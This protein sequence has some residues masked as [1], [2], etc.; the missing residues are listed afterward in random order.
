MLG[1]IRIK[2]FENAIIVN[3]L[4]YLEFDVFDN[5]FRLWIGDERNGF[6]SILDYLVVFLTKNE[7][8][9][10][11]NSKHFLLHE[12]V[13]SSGTHTLLAVRQRTRSARLEFCIYL[14]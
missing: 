12:I 13:Y 3:Q 1:C 7:I 6:N 14:G 4:A 8:L 5:I 9:S 2:C 10:C 11:D